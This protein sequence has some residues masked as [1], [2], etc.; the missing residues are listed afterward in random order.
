VVQFSVSEVA[1]FSMSLDTLA[2]S[3][4]TTAVPGARL[5]KRRHWSIH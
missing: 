4:A 5:L 3:L 1:Q 2:F